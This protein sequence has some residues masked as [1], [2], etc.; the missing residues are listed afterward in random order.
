LQIRRRSIRD[1]TQS[2]LLSRPGRMDGVQS[3]KKLIKFW[4]ATMHF[5]LKLKEGRELVRLFQA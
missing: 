2:D 1:S 4:L 3:A 5:R